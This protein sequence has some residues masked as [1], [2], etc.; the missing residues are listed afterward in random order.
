MLEAGGAEIPMNTSIHEHGGD[1]AVFYN[2]HITY[3][4]FEQCYILI[5]K[6]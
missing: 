4:G 3:Q 6:Y 2:Q 1:D 5:H